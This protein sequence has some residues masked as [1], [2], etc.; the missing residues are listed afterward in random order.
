MPLSNKDYQAILDIV[1]EMAHAFPDRAATFLVL[2]ERLDKFI[3]ISSAVLL[4]ITPATQAF[5]YPGSITYR[6]TPTQALTW[7]EHYVDLDPLVT[8]WDGAVNGAVQNDWSVKL[9]PG[10]E[11]TIFQRV[12]GG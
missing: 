8:H 2:C 10:A 5:E 12:A 3:G 1:A 11:V 4:P 6:C 9:E 7:I